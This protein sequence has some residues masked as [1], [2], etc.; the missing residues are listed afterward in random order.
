MYRLYYDHEI[1]LLRNLVLCVRHGC[2]I[3]DEASMMGSKFIVII[4][5]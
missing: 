5:P 3:Y 1:P 4:T 2:H